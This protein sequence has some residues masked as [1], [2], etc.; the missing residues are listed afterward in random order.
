MGGL[1]VLSEVF[2]FSNDG[3]FSTQLLDVHRDTR[4]RPFADQNPP[5]PHSPS[6]QLCAN[7]TLV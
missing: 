7:L 5:M 1:W 3:R 4:G 2:W 6:T